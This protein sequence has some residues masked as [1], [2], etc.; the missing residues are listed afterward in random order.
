MVPLACSLLIP[1]VLKSFNDMSDCTKVV[2]E[3]S[4]IVR[5]PSLHGVTSPA[6]EGS[7]SLRLLCKVHTIQQ[8]L[9]SI[10]K[11]ICLSLCCM[12]Q[13]YRIVHRLNS[14]KIRCWWFTINLSINDII[15]TKVNSES[16]ASYF[17]MLI[18]SYITIF[19][20]FIVCNFRIY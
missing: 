3:D 10:R 15:N 11:T 4:W 6:L 7:D 8:Y 13:F 20:G 1:K 5:S 2:D 18:A 14:D 16:S 12:I 9:W 19:K 17:D